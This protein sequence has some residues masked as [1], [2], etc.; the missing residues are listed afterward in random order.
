MSFDSDESFWAR[1]NYKNGVMDERLN[2]TKHI[3]ELESQ[4]VSG[5]YEYEYPIFNQGLPTF[6]L[7]D[8]VT[9][10]VCNG[11]VER[12]KELENILREF[13]KN[14]THGFYPHLKCVGC[15]AT[16]ALKGKNAKTNS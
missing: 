5:F 15:M 6:E 1:E 2:S 10:E 11:L 8:I 12:I 4:I 7:Q 9:A 3:K 16:E 13:A 14:H